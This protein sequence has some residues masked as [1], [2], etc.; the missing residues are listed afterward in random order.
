VRGQLDM[1][2]DKPLYVNRNSAGLPSFWKFKDEEYYKNLNDVAVWHA[3]DMEEPAKSDKKD[4][5]ENV[6]VVFRYNNGKPAV[7][8]K[9]VDAGEVLLVTTAASPS[10]ADADDIWT[11]WP[12]LLNVYVPFVDIAMSHLLHGQTQNYNVVAG[13]TLRWYPQ[14]SDV[15]VYKLI[16]PEGKEERLGF[17]E[18][19]QNRQIVT[20]HNLPTAGIY[21]VV[22]TLARSSDVAAADDAQ[23][24]EPLAVIP[25]LRESANLETL[26]PE[27]IDQ[28]LTFQP[29][30]VTAGDNPA[31]FF[32]E[33]RYN[34]EWTIWLLAVVL[35]LVLAESV[36]AWWCGKSW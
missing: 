4:T 5:A 3:L 10:G 27:A 21:K 18:K 25:D 24:S 2:L 7:L 16:N 36:L 12:I 11:T 22:S 20:A 34:R 33:E 8:S 29:L 35:A 15:R 31:T 6:H 26:T 13:E 19:V 23:T 1:P 9:K 14:E 17:A 32:G 28:R 30:H